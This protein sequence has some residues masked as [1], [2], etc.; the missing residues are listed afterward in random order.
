MVRGSHLVRAAV[1]LYVAIG[2]HQSL[3][4]V[5][6]IPHPSL[7]LSSDAVARAPLEAIIKSHTPLRPDMNPTPDPFHL[8]QSDSSIS[9][10]SARL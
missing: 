5:S 2:E 1:T 9:S 10:F 4:Q 3:N 8:F 6:Q 7:R